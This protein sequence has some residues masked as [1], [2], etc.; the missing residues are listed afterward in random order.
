MRAV[1]GRP[2]RRSKEKSVGGDRPLMGLS[3]LGRLRDFPLA[4]NV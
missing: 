4:S 2:A 1:E 3:M